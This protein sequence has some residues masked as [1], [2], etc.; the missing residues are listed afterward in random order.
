VVNINIANDREFLS[1]AVSFSQDWS[2]FFLFRTLSLKRRRSCFGPRKQ[3]EVVWIRAA[4][5]SN[6]SP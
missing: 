1:N 3:T 2:S 5:V 4:G 6:V